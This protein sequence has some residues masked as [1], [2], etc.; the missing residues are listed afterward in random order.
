MGVGG[1]RNAPDALPPVKGPGTHCTGGW[2]GP[3]Q[4]WCPFRLNTD[5]T[6][7]SKT[8]VTV[9]TAR[10]HVSDDRNVKA[11]D[12]AEEMITYRNSCDTHDDRE[13]KDRRPQTAW[14]YKPTA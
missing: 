1:Q 2:V 11:E 6:S 3:L 9:T 10:R 13:G 14:N 12:T 4:R 5:G 8:V 7:S